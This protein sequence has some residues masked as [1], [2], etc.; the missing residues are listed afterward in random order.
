MEQIMS[1]YLSY[2][3]SIK[4]RKVPHVF[5]F[6]DNVLCTL[7]NKSEIEVIN[8]GKNTEN[9]IISALNYIKSNNA[10]DSE[11]LLPSAQQPNY[12]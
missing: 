2:T 9:S 5:Y 6:K 11:V 4:R 7:L 10:F 1:F 8:L 12:C 3:K